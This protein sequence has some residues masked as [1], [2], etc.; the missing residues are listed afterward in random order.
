VTRKEGKVFY[1]P[2]IPGAAAAALLPSLVE[3]TV[4]RVSASETSGAPA[5]AGDGLA[6]RKVQWRE[7]YSF[8]DR[9]FQHSD[10]PAGLR[11]Q[12]V[13]AG[14]SDYVEQ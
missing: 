3:E 6:F 14:M 2:L 12:V 8:A 9:I 13:A 11:G 10:K 7:S 5:V 4:A 1:Y